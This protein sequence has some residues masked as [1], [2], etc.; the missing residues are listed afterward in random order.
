MKGQVLILL[1]LLA[2]SS[3]GYEE[4]IYK[5]DFQMEEAARQIRLNGLE[6]ER[7]KKPQDVVVIF[8]D[9]E[10]KFIK[11]IGPINA[12]IEAVGKQVIGIYKGPDIPSI[13]RIK[14]Y[15][16]SEYV[17]N[18]DEL[19]KF[20]VKHEHYYD[21]DNVAGNLK[22]FQGKAPAVV[23]YDSAGEQEATL[24]SAEQIESYMAKLKKKSQNDQ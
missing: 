15:I 12:L 5:I 19:K 4:K 24:E 13:K 17:D 7:F 20:V 22:V 1:S 11:L 8:W 16:N 21:A 23:I 9:Q 2:F 10:D 14:V 6:T 18:P 3:L